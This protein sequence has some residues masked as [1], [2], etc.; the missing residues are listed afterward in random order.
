MIRASGV[1]TVYVLCLSLVVPWVGMLIVIVTFSG[2]NHLLFQFSWFLLLIPIKC[3]TKFLVGF[4]CGLVQRV[5]LALAVCELGQF[6]LRHYN[7]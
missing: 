4:V 2:H 3:M 5:S 7:K 1:E 6:S